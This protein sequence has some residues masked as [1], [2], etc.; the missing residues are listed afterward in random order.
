MAAQSPLSDTARPTTAPTRAPV[1][2]YWDTPDRPYVLAQG[3]RQYLPPDAAI[4][5]HDPQLTAW[6]QRHGLTM[7]NG[8]PVVAATADGRNDSVF[9]KDVW[10]AQTG[11]FERQLDKQF[12]ASM[13]IIG[14]IT[15]AG[16][17][18]ALPAAGAGAASSGATVGGVEG[19]AAGVDAA[20][21][22]GLGTGAMGSTAV[23]AVGG[24]GATGVG[25]A[26]AAGGFD[27]AGNFIG[28]TTITGTSGAGGGIATTSAGL[29]GS[30][31]TYADLIKT[32]GGIVGSLIQ[33]NAAGNATEA[34][35][36]YLEEALAYAKEKDA[37]D[38]TIA[39]QRV[40]TEGGRYGDYLGRI[41]PWVSNGANAN[42]RM[43]ALLGLPA[44][45]GGNYGGAGGGQ[46]SG[47]GSP[48]VPV[49]PEITARIAQNYKDLGL[50]PT[51]PGSGPTD[52]AYY[53]TQDAAT[54]GLTDANN[55]Y[56]FGPT[57][58][59]ATD[60]AKAGLKG[61]PSTASPSAS[62]DAAPADPLITLKAPDGTTKQVPK[63]Q[64]PH[65]L[66]LGAV[67]V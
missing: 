64:A 35:Q 36:K 59:I 17:I 63:S 3:Q 55:N 7:Q 34:Q 5:L 31:L 23:P 4:F 60:A 38:R 21:V 28:D 39:A 9:S 20:A 49:S 19:G 27:A 13:A 32:G 67:A 54:G 30:G 52:A 26:S 62:P 44:R 61:T 24:A 14:G 50:T 1:P 22:G 12:I 57:G 66:S 43:S 53:A 58:R 16:V 15:G 42:D 29:G 10:N 48:G 33:A 6:A 40:A 65:F 56:W 45:T 18:A 11:Q 25:G 41:G 37:T 2:I 47:P 51:G 46:A 8:K